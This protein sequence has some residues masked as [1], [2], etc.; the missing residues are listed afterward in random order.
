MYAG[1]P[2]NLGLASNVFVYYAINTEYRDVIKQMF[3]NVVKAKKTQE[4]S[5]MHG[6]SR[7]KT[8]T[9]GIVVVHA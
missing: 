4:V 3:G 6:F 9:N 5:T 8:T 1:V 2:V 7:S